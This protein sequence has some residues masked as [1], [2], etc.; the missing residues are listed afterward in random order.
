MT[1]ETVTRRYV[2][3]RRTDRAVLVHGTGCWLPLSQVTVAETDDL[4][5]VINTDRR[6]RKTLVA[7]LPI[8]EVTMPK[9]LARKMDA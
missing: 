8:C 6:G 9:W 1:Q 3:A 7:E 5:P 2:I 4:Y